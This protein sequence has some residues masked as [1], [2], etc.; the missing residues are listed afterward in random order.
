[1]IPG[2]N[3]LNK[4]LGVIGRTAVQWYSSTGRTVNGIGLQ[5]TTFAAPITVYG[6]FQPVP[7]SAFLQ[8]GLDFAKEYVTFYTTQA[9]TDIER[10]KAPDEFVL[11]THRY[12]CLTKT[13]WKQIDG[14]N[15]PIAVRLTA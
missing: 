13:D 5:V 4:A 15:S 7:R 12:R 2:S 14:W 9:A 6:S 10:D 8:L 1:M 11:N 3:L